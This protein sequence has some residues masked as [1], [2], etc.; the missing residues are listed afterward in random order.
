MLD[1]YSNAG[2]SSCRGEVVKENGIWIYLDR[3]IV[4]LR[5]RWMEQ[6]AILSRGVLA[7][8][9]RTLPPRIFS[10]VLPC[11][12]ETFSSKISSARNEEIIRALL[13]SFLTMKSKVKSNFARTTLLVDL[14]KYLFIENIGE[15]GLKRDC[16]LAMR[17]SI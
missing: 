8:S 16:W 17:R 6:V 4:C 7:Y 15:V 9:Y 12:N 2:T 13:L 3:S 5:N 10:S 14:C 1:N 11:R